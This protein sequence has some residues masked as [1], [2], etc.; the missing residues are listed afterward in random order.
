[1]DDDDDGEDFN[2]SKSND[3]SQDP[4]EA[5]KHAKHKSKKSK[6]HKKDKKSK[7]DKKRSKSGR[8]TSAGEAPLE[9]ELPEPEENKTNPD[10]GLVEGDEPVVG[11]KR[12]RKF[13]KNADIEDSN[14]NAGGMEASPAKQ[15]GDDAP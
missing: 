11:Q 12:K 14:E 2:Q 13:R 4:L 1:M 8:K 7:K 15:D 10:D 6:K 3:D 5:E 9:S